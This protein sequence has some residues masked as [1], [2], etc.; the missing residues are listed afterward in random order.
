M[1]I[2]DYIDEKHNHHLDRLWQDLSIKIPFPGPGG[3]IYRQAHMHKVWS[4]IDEKFTSSQINLAKIPLGKDCKIFVNLTSPMVHMRHD[5]YVFAQS[6][7]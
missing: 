1:G 5:G 2:T 6:T 4:P 3:L 7:L